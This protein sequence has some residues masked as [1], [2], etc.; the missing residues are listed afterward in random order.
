MVTRF[1]ALVKYLEDCQHEILKV[2]IP[3]GNPL[4]MNL[5]KISISLKNIILKP[6]IPHGYRVVLGGFVYNRYVMRRHKLWH[7]IGLIG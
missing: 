1:C 5:M 3:T 7:D 2:N 6:I 4:F